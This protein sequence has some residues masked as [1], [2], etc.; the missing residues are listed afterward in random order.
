MTHTARIMMGI[1]LTVLAGVVA[2]L[3]VARAQ[4]GGPPKLSTNPGNHVIFPA[5]GQS[6]EQQEKDQTDAYTWASQQT[7][8]DPYKA[9][10]ELAKQGA[11][12]ANTAAATHG[13]AVKGAARG[14]V[15]GVAVGAIAG[16]AGKG[17]AIG[18]T[19]GGLTSGMKSRQVRKGAEAGAEAASDA[20]KHQFEV[21]DKH[22]VAAMEG[23][24]YSVK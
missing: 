10:A 13:Q 7:Q 11:A 17:A 16:D 1:L 4:E 15:V 9:H 21:W 5:K 6:A 23:K 3:E 19:A 24:G 2:T 20:Y 18:A 14:A 22:F 8:W 12:A